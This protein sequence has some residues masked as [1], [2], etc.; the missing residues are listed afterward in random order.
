MKF[1]SEI[2]VKF[3]SEFL[4]SSDLGFRYIWTILLK[5]LFTSLALG[6]LRITRHV[7]NCVLA[8]L[9]ITR[10]VVNYAL[11]LLWITR[12]VVNSVF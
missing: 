10:D 6:C 8:C 12:D 3:F 9:R 11:A 5:F 7:V 1:C 2:D 4:L